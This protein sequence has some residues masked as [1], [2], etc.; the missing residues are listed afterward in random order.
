MYGEVTSNVASVP[1][2]D[3][4][5]GRGDMDHSCDFRWHG[6]D[7]GTAEAVFQV[8]NMPAVNQR[9]RR[10][11][12]LGKTSLTATDGFTGATLSASANPVDTDI[13]KIGRHDEQ[14]ERDAVI[15]NTI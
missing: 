4:G 9:D 12:L 14:P 10:C 3:L 15:A 11:T 1:V 7:R 6:R 8:A 2:C 13:P 5:D